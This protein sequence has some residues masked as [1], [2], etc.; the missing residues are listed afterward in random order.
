MTCFKFISFLT[1]LLTLTIGCSEH[2]DDEDYT[3]EQ[4][5]KKA[6]YTDT[7]QVNQQADNNV[8]ID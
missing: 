8:I 1:L 3:R 7:L 4:A 5:E 2:C 6:I